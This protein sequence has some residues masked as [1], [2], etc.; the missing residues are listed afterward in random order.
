M[1]GAGRP[2]PK[3]SVPQVGCWAKLLTS[4]RASSARRSDRLPGRRPCSLQVRSARRASPSFLLPRRCVAADAAVIEKAHQPVAVIDAIA[5]WPGRS[6][7]HRRLW[8]RF[9]RAELSAP[10]RCPRDDKRCRRG[11]RRHSSGALSSDARP[12]LRAGPGV[13]LKRRA[14]GLEVC[15]LPSSLPSIA[16]DLR[17]E[18]SH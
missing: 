7:K 14:H 18:E 16:F 2:R 10:Q 8:A 12:G 5:D 1:S 6:T 11:R 9:S 3:A 17:R 13:S 4:F 15:G